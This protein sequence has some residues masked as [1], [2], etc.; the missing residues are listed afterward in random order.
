M[1]LITCNPRK[2]IVSDVDRWFDSFWNFDY[3]SDSG[4]RYQPLFDIQENEHSYIISADLPGIEKKD[5]NIS[6]SEGEI[7]ISGERK[8]SEN[9]DCKAHGYPSSQYGKFEKSF[10]LPEDVNTDKVT[11]KMSNG[12]LSLDIQKAKKIPADI[13]KISIK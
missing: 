11:A 6:I 9:D 1:T 3:R 8:R 12:V 10:F 4:Y 5:V 7:N 13:K 2:T